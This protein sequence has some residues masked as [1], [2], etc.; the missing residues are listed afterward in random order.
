MNAH[1]GFCG[2]GMRASLA[3]APKETP[4]NGVWFGGWVLC[5]DPENSLGKTLSHLIHLATAP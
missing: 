5:D 4:T 1:F 2:A 3:W